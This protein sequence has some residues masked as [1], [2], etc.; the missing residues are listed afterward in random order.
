MELKWLTSL[1]V[2]SGINSIGISWPK[3]SI[4]IRSA[5]SI[6]SA[7]AS[8]CSKGTRGSYDPCITN[9]DT[10]ISLSLFNLFG[11]AP[12]AAVCKL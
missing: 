2:N 5:P 6:C 8:P 7:I 3:P 11:L 10:L 1:F 9:L 4:I 12:T